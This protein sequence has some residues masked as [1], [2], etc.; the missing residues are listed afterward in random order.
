MRRSSLQ[1]EAEF[2][3]VTF[4]V[5]A[6]ICDQAEARGFLGAYRSDL[7]LGSESLRD[8]EALETLRK[9]ARILLSLDFRGDDYQ[10]PAFLS[11]NESLWPARVI[12]MTLARVGSNAGPDLRPLARDRRQSQRRACRLCGGRCA[13]RGRSRSIGAKQA[14]RGVLVASALH[15]GRLDA[16]TLARFDASI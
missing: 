9:E 11:E 1:L 15:D 2:P 12:V 3:S 14:I 16:K 4:W 6:G 13:R 7:V 5:D 8:A 10:G